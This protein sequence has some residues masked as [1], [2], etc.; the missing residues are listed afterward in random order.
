MRDRIPM[1]QQLMGAPQT[2]AN[3]VAPTATLGAS[4]TTASTTAT[5]A[6]P[7]SAVPAA[8]ASAAPPSATPAMAQPEDPRFAN[9]ATPAAPAPSSA[10]AT[11]ET[12]AP[13]ARA[14]EVQPLTELVAARAAEAAPVQRTL[15]KTTTPEPISTPRRPHVP[16]IAIVAGGDEVI[17]EPAE[18]AI[19]AALSKRGYHMID[20]D[21]M[22]RVAHLLG[23]GK[24]NTAGVLAALSGRADA[25]IV[26]H[27]RPAGSENITY[28]GQSSTLNTAQLNVTAFAVDGARKLGGGSEQVHFT[29]LNASDQAEE[30][31]Q[32]MLPQ[33]EERL[34][35]F[36]PSR[37]R[38]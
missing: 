4:N 23:G 1:L 37:H 20:Q 30:A 3:S 5:V 34:T 28:Y 15:A 8:V 16:T 12:P 22:P 14:S 26:V 13:A 19:E 10:T 7:A 33:L 27:A 24:P 35:E 2:T 21:T 25:V 17:T 38:E 32:G 11:P 36:L 6:Q 29:S 9:T 31:V 18:R